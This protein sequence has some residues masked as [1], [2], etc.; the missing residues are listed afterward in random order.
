MIGSV[1]DA[2]RALAFPATDSHSRTEAAMTMLIVAAA[3][4]LALHLLIAGTRLRDAITGAIGEGP[5]MGL[6]S[7]A[8]LGGIVWLAV[9]YNQAVEAGS[10]L[11]WN[12]GPGVSHLGIIVVGLAFLIGVSG[13]TTPNP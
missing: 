9:S 3:A 11:L 13:L 2:S 1:V 8:S 6:F 10:D 12:L 4:F 5:Y 7:L